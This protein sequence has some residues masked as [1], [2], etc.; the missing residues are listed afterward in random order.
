MVSI[1]ESRKVFE[2]MLTKKD[3]LDFNITNKQGHN[4]LHLAVLNGNLKLKEV[5]T[6]E[7]INKQDNDGNTPLMFCKNSGHFKILLEEGADVTITNKQGQNIFHLI[8]N[9]SSEHFKQNTEYFKAIFEMAENHLSSKIITKIINAKD[10]NG[11]TILTMAI[12]N[13]NTALLKKLTELAEIQNTCKDL[14]LYVYSVELLEKDIETVGKYFSKLF[15]ELL[16][17]DPKNALKWLK[18]Y[19]DKIEN[20]NKLLEDALSVVVDSFGNW[21]PTI[22]YDLI[23][24]TLDIFDLSTVIEPKKNSNSWN[25]S[26]TLKDKIYDCINLLNF[27]EVSID[28]I[29]HEL[30]FEVLESNVTNL[31][32][33]SLHKLKI[34]IYEAHDKW[35]KLLTDIDKIQSLSIIY[36]S[37]KNDMI[38]KL[39]NRS[40]NK[41]IFS[42]LEKFGLVNSY[43]YKY[44]HCREF[45]S[46]LESSLPN[47]KNA[48]KII[49]E[50]RKTEEELE[51]VE[52]NSSV[53]SVY[54][55]IIIKI[56]CK[57]AKFS[58]ES[59]KKLENIF[60]IDNYSLLKQDLIQLLT[61]LKP[62]NKDTWENEKLKHLCKLNKTMKTLIKELNDFDISALNNNISYQDVELI[63]KIIERIKETGSETKFEL[64]IFGSDFRSFE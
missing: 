58:N 44:N 1:C 56:A 3:L 21:K 9:N 25:D 55:E 63:T 6:K 41:I 49:E 30:L 18:S 35:K 2:L 10:N 48:F 27:K 8:A 37:A 29:D 28:K 62:Q 24:N 22:N 16:K 64:E 52:E 19:H 13:N 59:L 47:A 46:N 57:E 33:K 43:D 42:L 39:I 5:I 38:S 50:I 36:Q 45:C 51:Q 20:K 53:F 61:I 40:D 14:F 23:K 31:S 26:K 54:K 15:A 4:I 11:E 32:E 7:I 17:S 12:K 60:V 34:S